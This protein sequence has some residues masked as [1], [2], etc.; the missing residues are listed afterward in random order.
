MLTVEGVYRN[1]AKIA[2]FVENFVRQVGFDARSIYA[3]QMAVDEAC[4]NIIEHGYGGEGNGD[5]VLQCQRIR[6]GVKVII[7]DQGTPFDPS[8][9][10]IPDT[11]APLEERSEGGL[12][13]FLMRQLMDEVSFDFAGGDHGDTNTLVLIKRV[14][15]QTRSLGPRKK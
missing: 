2:D 10:P 11:E 7:Q 5:I 15:G 13:L 8:L 14:K 12:G 1:L 9:V 4:S 3:V 6:G